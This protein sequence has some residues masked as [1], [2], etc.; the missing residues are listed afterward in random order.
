MSASPGPTSPSSD[1]RDV[2]WALKVSNSFQMLAGRV[3]ERGGHPRMIQTGYTRISRAHIC[4]GSDS[5]FG[6]AARIDAL[7]RG[8]LNYRF[9]R[10][11]K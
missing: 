11:A 10:G 2:R 6:V 1:P 8:S 3:I 9:Q 4:L 7:F 5:I